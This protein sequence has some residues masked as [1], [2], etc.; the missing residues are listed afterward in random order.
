M[1]WVQPYAIFDGKTLLQN[2][3]IAIENNKI[4]QLTDVA[5]LKPGA[6][7][8]TLS[9]IL[10]PGLF[11]IQVNGGGGVM[12]NNEPTRDGVRAIAAAHRSVG[13]PFILP[14]VITDHQ[15]IIDR[16]ADAVLAEY[17]KNG[18]LGI[19]IEGPHI[20]FAHKGTHDSTRIR[21]F[22]SQTRDLLERLRRHDLPV[23]LTVAPETLEP[24]TIADLTK[25]GVVVSAGHSAATAEQTEQALAEGL[26]GFTHL[27]NGMPQ[28]TSR[29]PG[30]V[31]AAINSTAYCGIIADGHHVD[32]T[33]IAIAFRARPCEQRMV[34][35]SDAMSTIAGPDHF[36][37]YDEKIKVEHGKLVNSKGSLAGAHIDLK[38]SVIRLVENVGLTPIQALTS[39]T[40]APRKFMNIAR[41][42]LLGSHIDDAFLAPAWQFSP[43]LS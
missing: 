23:M 26:R 34:L 22:D 42:S 32:D 28:I 17:S 36:M 7:V 10:S 41:Q 19:H 6:K 33:M 4:V 39:A 43:K 38:S 2:R 9:A 16:A 25:M 8:E 30:I 31:G 29:A 24:G 14:T 35:V 27:F 18:V 40:T 3:V 15:D 5:K 21:P 20:S 1:R 12:L 37:L 13:T 11:D